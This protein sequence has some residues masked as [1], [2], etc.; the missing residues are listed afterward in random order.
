MGR[1]AFEFGLRP[2]DQF[3]VMQHFDLNTN[4]L[5]VLN[6]LYTPLIGTQAVGLY[7]F[8]TQFVKESHNETLILS[9]YIFMNELKINLL[10]FRQQMDLLEAIGLLK[11]FVKHDEQ[12][13]QFVYQ[14]IQPP[15]AH[16]FFND[17]DVN[18]FYIVKSSI[19]DFMS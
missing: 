17:P 15:S 12:K 14:L 18:C 8:M 7:H 13:T 6:R 4:H 10:E 5:E 9:H 11:A 16:L 19:V 1:Q 3:K 2:K